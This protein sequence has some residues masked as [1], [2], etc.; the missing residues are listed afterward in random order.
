[1]CAALERVADW[2]KRTVRRF[3]AETSDYHDPWS[4]LLYPDCGRQPDWRGRLD[5]LADLGREGR[6]APL[7]SRGV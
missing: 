6:R 7:G 1:M 2:I 5:W 3:F 4:R